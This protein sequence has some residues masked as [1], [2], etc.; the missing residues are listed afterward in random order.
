M[1]PHIPITPAM[2]AIT[3]GGATALA[4]FYVKPLTFF[5]PDGKPR[6]ATWATDRKDQ[7]EEAVLIPWWAAAIAVGIAVDL[8][9]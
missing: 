7:L 9:I 1:N 5:T 3:A 6:V 8:F 2:R 4:L